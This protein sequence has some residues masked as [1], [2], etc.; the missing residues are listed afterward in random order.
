MIQ[1]EELEIRMPGK[2]AEDGNELGRQVAEKL[3]ET[4]PEHSGAHHIPELKVRMQ[5]TALNSTTQLVD[6]IAVQIIRQIKL[7]TIYK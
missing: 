6:C 2:N 1:I 3:A 7:E 4:M 5:S